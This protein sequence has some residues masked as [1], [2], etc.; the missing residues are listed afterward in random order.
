MLEGNPVLRTREGERPLAKGDVLHFVC[1]ADGAHKLS[2]S[3]DG[4]VRYMMVSNFAS[5]DVVEYPDIGQVSVMA[6]T[7]S[8]LGEPLWHMH[9]ITDDSIPDT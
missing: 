6:V 1:G 4:L 5:P 7:E 9:S 8:Q 3:T 2:N